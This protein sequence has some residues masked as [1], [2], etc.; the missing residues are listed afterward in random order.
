MLW[1]LSEVLMSLGNPS[2]SDFT[3][4]M[5]WWWIVKSQKQ[6]F[7]GCS[8]GFTPPPPPEKKWTHQPLTTV[9]NVSLGGRCIVPICGW[10]VAVAKQTLRLAVRCGVP[11]VQ[12]AFVL[13]VSFFNRKSPWVRKKNKCIKRW[14]RVVIESFKQNNVIS[15][16]IWMH[17]TCMFETRINR[18]GGSAWEDR[19][20]RLLRNNNNGIWFGGWS[21]C[22]SAAMIWSHMFVA[23]LFGG[24]SMEPKQQLH[25]FNM[26]PFIFHFGINRWGSFLMLYTVHFVRP[27]ICFFSKSWAERQWKTSPVGALSPKEK[28]KLTAVL[29]ALS[30]GEY[31]VSLLNRPINLYLSILYRRGF[32]GLESRVSMIRSHKGTFFFAWLFTQVPGAFQNRIAG[33]YVQAIGHGFT[34]HFDHALQDGLEQAR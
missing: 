6:H 8:T 29:D 21:S 30:N 26:V 23:D 25:M 5:D 24:Q 12:G 15:H 33:C 1:K 19:K 13:R 31:P 28:D 11:S 34:L 2:F 32:K 10:K 16:G 3:L 27:S 22:L 7:L 9:A 4:V 20:K 17:L 18:A 14:S